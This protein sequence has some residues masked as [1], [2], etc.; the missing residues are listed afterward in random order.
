MQVK[1]SLALAKTLGFNLLKELDYFLRVCPEFAIKMN[2][3]Y[4]VHYTNFINQ[5]KVYIKKYDIQYY[6][7]E[8]KK[9]ETENKLKELEALKRYKEALQKENE[10][11]IR[12]KVEEE[13][14]RLEKYYEQ[15]YSGD[16]Q[17]ISVKSTTP[18]P[19]P[20]PC[21]LEQENK[22]LKFA[23]NKANEKITELRRELANAN[24]QIRNYERT[25][26]RFKEI[27]GMLNDEL[28]HK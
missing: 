22:T 28:N 2:E 26:A 5:L 9:E 14:C 25:I 20:E 16:V 18:E 11:I 6:R 12:K 17:L 19:K 10:E 1:T 24:E 8:M 13:K 3:A 7:R 4:T 23:L 21:D 15:K 27:H